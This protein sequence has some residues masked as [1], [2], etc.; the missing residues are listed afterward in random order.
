MKKI[1]AK[2]FVGSRLCWL[3]LGVILASN[4]AQNVELTI[5]L[6]ALVKLCFWMRL[7]LK[8]VDSEYT[9]KAEGLNTAQFDFFQA[10]RNFISRLNWDLKH[11]FFSGL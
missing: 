7:I 9:Q 8:L 10:K 6:V 2:A 11:S 1:L 5:I 3:I 4:S